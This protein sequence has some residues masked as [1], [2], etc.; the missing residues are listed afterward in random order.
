MALI[1]DASP[2]GKTHQLKNNFIADPSKRA[3]PHLSAKSALRSLRSLTPPIKILSPLLP[4]ISSGSLN[5][6]CSL[7]LIK[8]KMSILRKEDGVAHII[9]LPRRCGK[10]FLRFGLVR[11]TRFISFSD[12]FIIKILN[13][14]R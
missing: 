11:L 3:H 2:Q 10:I 14:G 4:L 5:F 8:T 1:S 7:V 6:R 12:G 9:R 13:F